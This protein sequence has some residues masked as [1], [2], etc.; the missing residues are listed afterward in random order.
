MKAR[1]K[2]LALLLVTA[3]APILAQSSQ[4]P[5]NPAPQGPAVN[6]FKPSSA[7]QPGSEYP[8]VNSER[9]V[10]VRIAAP[11]AKTVLL[12]I[13]AVRYPLTKME[14]GLWVG[15]SA[16]QDEGFHYYQ[17]WIDGA[18]VPDPGSL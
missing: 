13:G 14:D 1:V 2:M 16:P 3:A 9:R 17:V 8:Q 5:S 18:K 4:A 11:D 12:D 15:D 7:N 10:R 6:D